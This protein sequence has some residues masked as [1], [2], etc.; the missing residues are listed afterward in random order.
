MKKNQI[1]TSLI[2]GAFLVIIFGFMLFTF[3][4]REGEVAIKTRFGKA[5]LYDDLYVEG[6]TLPD[7]KAVG[8][9]KKYV[10]GDTLPDG[11]AVG[12]VKTKADIGPGLHLRLPWPV[13]DV[14]TFDKRIQSSEWVFEETG[15]KDA[16]PILIKVFVTWR[17]SNAELFF[18][19]HSGDLAKADDALQG[20]VRSAQNAVIGKYAFNE[21]VSTNEEELKLDDIEDEMRTRVG[22]D[23]EDNGIEIIMVGIK[24]LGIPESNTGAVFERMKAERQA[25][26]QKIEAEG[27]RQAKTIKAEADLVANKILALARAEAIQISGEA[28]AQAAKY[29]EV[30]KQNPELANFLFQRKAL[31]GLLKENSTLILDPNTPPFNLLTQPDATKAAKP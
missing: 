15:T 2:I 12:D 8:D 31:E 3:Q 24:R 1:N 27:E 13:H 30:F 10:E 5:V 29:Y 14:H 16:Q 20:K 11:K 9:A 28:E 23:S 7:G 26:I 18:D 19:R 25:E 17:I 21:L 22:E 4:V 6:D